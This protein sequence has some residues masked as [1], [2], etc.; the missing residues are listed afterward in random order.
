MLIAA[1]VESR[2]P[3][4]SNTQTTFVW[5]RVRAA[6]TVSDLAERKMD[7]WDESS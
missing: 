6:A 7:V 4:R 3:D 5:N 2:L 1:P